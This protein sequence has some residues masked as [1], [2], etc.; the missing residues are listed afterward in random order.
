MPQLQSA[1]VCRRWVPAPGVPGATRGR[2][3]PP[4]PHALLLAS[5][6][7]RSISR[8]STTSSLNPKSVIL[9]LAY[10]GSRYTFFSSA[11][12]GFF[13]LGLALD[14]L[15]REVRQGSR[16]RQ[17]CRPQAQLRGAPRGLQLLRPRCGRKLPCASGLPALSGPKPGTRGTGGLQPTRGRESG[18]TSRLPPT[19]DTTAPQPH[20]VLPDVLP[21]RGAS[22]PPC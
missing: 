22:S 16:Q 3:A 15:R 4:R 8:G 12:A 19:R 10:S 20:R 13:P 18:H 6:S 5:H 1:C 11:A 7:L 9:D 17:A 14:F 2:P 21:H